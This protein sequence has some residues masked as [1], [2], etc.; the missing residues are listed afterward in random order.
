MGELILIR[1]GQTEWSLSGRHAG[2]TDIPLTD[3]EEAT[4]KALA[5]RP[6]RRHLAAVPRGRSVSL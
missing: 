4:A 2:R 1:H 6:A 5:Q 3:A